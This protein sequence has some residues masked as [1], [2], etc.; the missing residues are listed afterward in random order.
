MTI[1]EDRPIRKHQVPSAPGPLCDLDGYRSFLTGEVDDWLDTQGRPVGEIRSGPDTRCQVHTRYETCRYPGS[2]G[3]SGLPMNVSA[4]RGLTAN[5]AEVRRLVQLLRA[6]Y[7][8]DAGPEQESTLLDVARISYFGQQLPAYYAHSRAD[9]ENHAVPPSLAALHKMLA[10]VF[11]TAK[12]MLLDAVGRG[13]VFDKVVVTP[14]Q[15]VDYA[16]Q[17]GLLVGRSGTEVCAGPPKLIDEV[18]HRL[19]ARPGPPGDDSEQTALP[20][21][22]W[23]AFSAYAR[24]VADFNLTTIAC[25]IRGR[26]LGRRLHSILAAGPLNRMPRPSTRLIEQH[27]ERHGDNGFGMKSQP[28]LRLLDGSSGELMLRGAVALVSADLRARMTDR[29][30]DP[31]YTIEDSDR[32]DY[33]MEFLYTSGILALAPTAAEVTQLATLVSRSVAFED[34]QIELQ[35]SIHARMCTAVPGSPFAAIKPTREIVQHLFGE[36]PTSYFCIPTSGRYS[37]R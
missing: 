5:W 28:Q 25:A 37:R 2:R 8:R 21:I 24:A 27:F 31:S 15:F 14:R 36:L 6:A 1:E 35:Q 34:E 7:Y 32:N 26:E 18:V 19:M 11:G 30:L 9:V 13:G 3:H 17:H 20:P 4:L 10:G 23:P 16:E 33:A 12:T 29:L 22:D